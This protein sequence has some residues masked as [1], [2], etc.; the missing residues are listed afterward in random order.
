MVAVQDD[1]AVLSRKLRVDLRNLRQEANRTQRQ[2]ASEMDWSTSKLIRIENGDVN[3]S[4]NDLKALLGFYGVRDKR[5]VNEYVEL[6]KAARKDPWSKFR[7]VHSAEFLT[8]LAYESSAQR[9]RDF[10]S[11]FVP[12]LLQTEEYCWAIQTR[13][14]DHSADEAE[15]RW[16]ARRRRQELHERDHP[17]EM[18]FILDEAV[19]RRRVGGPKVMLHQLER[20][21]EWSTASHITLQ[22]VLFE[23][24][25]H[26]GMKGPFILLDFQDPNLDDLLYLE[27][28]TGEVTSRDNTDLIIRHLD[29][30][31]ALEEAALS[32]EAT[33]E[34]LDSAIKDLKESTAETVPAGMAGG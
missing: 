26:Q 4:T 7:D 16:E 24:G 5:Q 21:R 18:F 6:A 27:L 13:A 25:A 14:R 10:Q 34:L 9:I 1:P 33:R 15:L 17:P 32:A 20:L 12:G 2:V 28:P 29:R 30:F 11:A 8:Y 19:I 23:A 3:I 22:V 31:F